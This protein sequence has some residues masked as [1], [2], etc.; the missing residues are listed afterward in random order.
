[1]VI[2]WSLDENLL[3]SGPEHYIGPP[4]SAGRILRPDYRAVDERADVVIDT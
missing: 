1:V 3:E 2:A 4:F